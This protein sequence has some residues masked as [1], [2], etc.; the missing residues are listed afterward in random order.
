MVVTFVGWVRFLA[1]KA[2]PDVAGN[3]LPLPSLPKEPYPHLTVNDLN[4]VWLS[5]GII[6]IATILH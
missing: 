5:R 1:E 2:T 3:V 6:I 4:N